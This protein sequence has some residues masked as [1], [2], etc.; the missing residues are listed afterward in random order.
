MFNCDGAFEDND[1]A[2]YMYSFGDY[3]KNMRGFSFSATR[4]SSIFGTSPTV[5]P[6]AL[7]LLPCIKT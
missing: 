2:E 7:I 5:Q 3:K 4:S 1:F 6:A